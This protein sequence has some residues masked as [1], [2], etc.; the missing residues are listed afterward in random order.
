MVKN[1]VYSASARV[2]LYLESSKDLKLFRIEIA[3][4]L[5]AN[6]HNRYL[7]LISNFIKNNKE[8]YSSFYNIQ[9]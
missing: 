2:H 6:D 8:K 3:K 9:K 5:R 7:E 1:G 4:T